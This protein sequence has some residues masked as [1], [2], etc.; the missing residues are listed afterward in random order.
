MDA[1][2]G[3]SSR[4]GKD[5]MNGHI[6]EKGRYVVDDA[7]PD[8]RTYATL[9]H[10]SI[11][12]HSVFSIL[13]FAIPLIMWLVKK[14]ES[15]YINDH[16]REAVNFQISL[17]IYSLIAGLFAIV[18]IGIPFLIAIPIVAIIFMVFAS[19]AANRGELYRY[20]M[21]IRFLNG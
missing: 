16:G 21:T 10:L 8:E 5:A 2:M 3:G 19:M 20:P 9:I 7:S 13:A 1:V 6:N 11:L 12:A 17:G 14:D 15:A 4:I 18:L